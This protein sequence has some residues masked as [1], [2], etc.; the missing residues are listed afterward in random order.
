LPRQTGQGL[1]QAGQG[2]ALAGQGKPPRLLEFL[3]LR[4][5]LVIFDDAS[6]LFVP[7]LTSPKVFQDQRVS[8][9]LW[10]K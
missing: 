7:T 5:A 3:S 1:A 8:R 4:R 9:R 6:A 2:L 10:K